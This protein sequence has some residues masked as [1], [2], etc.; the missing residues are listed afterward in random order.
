[1][2]RNVR[3]CALILGG[4][5]VLPVWAAAQG[6]GGW[7]PRG[8]GQGPGFGGPM[9]GF[10]HN[11]RT[12]AELGLTD[13]QSDKLHQI[14]LDSRKA[15]IKTRADLQIRRMELHEILGAD[16]TDR[17]AAM[18]KVQEISDLRG[19]MMRQHVESMLAAKSVL[20]PEQQKKIHA[21]MAERMSRRGEGFRARREFRGGPGGPGGGQGGYGRLDGPPRDFLPESDEY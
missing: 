10:L 5:L 4:L 17:E 18:K 7:G 9:A 15:S 2:K 11:E 13:E 8:G 3:T 6:P 1:M 19:Q 16:K 21:M 12:K 14:F 20:T